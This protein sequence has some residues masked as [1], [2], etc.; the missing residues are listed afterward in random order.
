MQK[1]TRDL[2]Q[3]DQNRKKI[4]YFS[5]TDTEKKDIVISGDK[6]LFG[7]TTSCAGKVLQ[8]NSVMTMRKKRAETL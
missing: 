2:L 6:F 4:R 1:H 3:K 7:P 8:T 5:P